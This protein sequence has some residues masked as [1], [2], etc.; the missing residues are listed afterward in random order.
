MDLNKLY[1]LDCFEGHKQIQNESIDL[2]ITD[3]PY[4]TTDCE[5]DGLIDLYKLW[6]DYR[7]IIKS[8]GAILIFGTGI[9]I[10]Q[11]IL[12]NLANFK[13]DIVWEKER[14]VNIFQMKK[15][16]GRVHENIAVFYKKQCTYNPIMEDRIFRTIGVFGKDKKSNTHKNQTYKYSK[17]YDPTK[18]YP[19]S[20]LKFNRDTLKGS[21]HPTQKPVKLLEYLINIFSNE[22]D[23]ILDS[24]AGS[25][26]TCIACM[27][28]NRNY[29][30]FEK[31]KEIFDK[32]EKRIKEINK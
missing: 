23:L 30:A 15:Q 27:N 31:D 6:Y 2:I 3:P 11:V 32:A 17:D 26:S 18:T 19:R 4:N 28:T 13:Y 22:N 7:R 9:F 12:S 29:I 8:N 14:P 20:V 24:F 10:S 25:G 16:I 21:I 5:W 1:N